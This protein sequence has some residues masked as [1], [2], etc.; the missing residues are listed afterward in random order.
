ML[1]ARPRRCREWCRWRG[2]GVP[3]LR[4]GP[5]DLA[6]EDVP[7]AGSGPDAP[8]GYPLLSILAQVSFKLTVRLKTGRPGVASGST[9]KYPRRSNW[10]RE[11][12]AGA[13]TL[14]STLQPVSTRSDCGL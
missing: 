2:A 3:N 10:Y 8:C 13:A 7:A 11:P 1:A 6:P 4:R 12:G 5:C 14:G 9:Q